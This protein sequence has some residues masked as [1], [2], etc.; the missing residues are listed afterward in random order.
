MELWIIRDGEKSGPL[1]DYEVREM[2]RSGEVGPETRVWHEGAGGWLRADEVSVLTGEFR[3]E[4]EPP[5]IP[6]QR[7][8]F[9]PWRRFGARFFDLISYS[10]ILV[11]AARLT[12][13]GLQ[14]DENV[15]PSPWLIIG[16]LLPAILIEAALLGS[17]GFT[18]GKWL[19]RM[20]VETMDGQRLTTGQAFVRSMRVWILGM[21]MREPILMALGHL[22]S[23]W[24]GLK[25]GALLWDLQSGFEVRAE[26]LDARRVAGFAGALVTLI[27]L[28]FWALWPQLGPAYAE[29]LEEMRS[30]MK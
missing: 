23:L 10:L 17:V 22:L 18:P 14:S 1:E 19:L 5:P 6:L 2:V 30:Q 28:S 15:A 4:A 27:G 26:E 13:G 24:F 12:D 11:V 29:A 21:G 3:K 25:K 8:R 20:R 7:E 9:R 16:T